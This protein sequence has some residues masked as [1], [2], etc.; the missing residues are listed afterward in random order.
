MTKIPEQNDQPA[1]E[2]ADAATVPTK[3]E[4]LEAGPRGAV[5]L[6]EAELEKVAGGFF[7]LGAMAFRTTTA[8]A[9]EEVLVNKS[10]TADKQ[11]NAMDGFIK[12]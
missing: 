11:F 7:G 8:K 6:D 3:D 9:T 1:V 4:L 5:E 10:K 2:N 12:G